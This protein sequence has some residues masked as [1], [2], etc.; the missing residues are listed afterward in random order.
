MNKES[1]R[2]LL[3]IAHEVFEPISKQEIIKFLNDEGYVTEPDI[4]RLNPINV[5]YGNTRDLDW[6]A[7]KEHQQKWF[8]SDEIQSQIMNAK[9]HNHQICYFGFVPIPLAVH[10]GH[11]VGSSTNVKIFQKSPS[12]GK[13][14]WPKE[15]FF[16]LKKQNNYNIKATMSGAVAVQLEISGEINSKN[17]SAVLPNNLMTLQLE[18]KDVKRGLI[19]SSETINEIGNAFRV[20]LEKTTKKD[21][22]I[23]E[24]HLFAAVPAGVAF[25]IGQEIAKTMHAPVYTYEYHKGKQ[26]NYLKTYAIQEESNTKPIISEETQKKIIA[27][28]ECVDEQLKNKISTIITRV[29]IQVKSNWFNSIFPSLGKTSFNTDYW[30]GLH[31][32][33]KTELEGSSISYKPLDSLDKN[34]YLNNKWWLSDDFLYGLIQRFDDQIDLFYQAVR[35]FFYREMIHRRS[36]QIRSEDEE[37]MASFPNILSEADYK[38]D[39]YAILHECLETP[40]SGGNESKFFIDLIDII[41]ETMWAEENHVT[42]RIEVRRLN[43]YL[44]WYFQ[45]S[46]IHRS[47]CRTLEDVLDILAYRPLI[48]LKL[49]NVYTKDKKRVEINLEGLEAKELAI[50]IFH[51]NEVKIEEHGV[52]LNLEDLINGFK[53]RNPQKIK[54]IMSKLLV[55]I[56]YEKQIEQC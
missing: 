1:T 31:R 20:L 30:K 23:N 48:E 54:N 6:K 19:N 28:R 53:E 51:Q 34:Y 33:D 37:E 49:H 35:L 27:W 52:R 22:K 46:K 26:P 3:V 38:A 50:A 32:L 42:N 55:N 43:R 29:K 41:T 11:L 18:A 25:R 15:S 14:E 45:Q 17:I 7:L 56:G 12:S 40:P 24:I 5:R 44:T 16:G 47:D 10:F 21:S 4:I 9:K 13:W 36:H 8:D 39:V 2:R